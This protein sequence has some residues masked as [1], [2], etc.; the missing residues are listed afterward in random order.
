MVLAECVGTRACGG[1]GVCALAVKGCI[2]Q[3]SRLALSGRE[4]QTL[5]STLAVR[6][7]E[8]HSW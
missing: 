4:C 5:V 7:T 1:G 6:V 8:S 2:A 3:S